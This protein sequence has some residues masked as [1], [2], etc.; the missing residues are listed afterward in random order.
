MFLPLL[1]LTLIISFHKISFSQEEQTTALVRIHVDTTYDDTED[2]L[3]LI[4]K[5]IE[6]LPTRRVKLESGGT[7]SKLILDEYGFGPSDL[8]KSYAL[9]EAAILSRNELSKPEDAMPGE[10]SIPHVPKRALRLFNKNKLLNFVS[11]IAYF[12]RS[13]LAMITDVAEPT[14]VE[15]VE[16]VAAPQVFEAGRP[17]AQ[18]TVDDLEIPAA[19]AQDILEDE[20][21]ATIATGFNLPMTV[22]LASA[23]GETSSP[24]DTPHPA[25]NEEERQLIRNMLATEA[26]RDVLVFIADTG[27]PDDATYIQ[28]RHNLRDVLGFIWKQ[29]F[30]RDLPSSPN[31]KPFATPSHKHCQI[32]ERSLGEF[33][34]LDP[35]NRIK[36]VYVPM[37]KEQD[38]APVLIELL[39]TSYLIDHL[40][41][42]PGKVPDDV[43]KRAR[44]AAEKVVAENFPSKWEGQE[45]K[46]DKAVLDALLRVGDKY[47]EKKQ[48]LF[49]LNESWTVPIEELFVAYPSLLDGAVIAA[50]GNSMENVNVSLRDFAQ[51]SVRNK[52]TLAVMNMNR[53]GSLQCLSSRIDERDIDDAF[54]VAFDGRV[55]G[56]DSECGT[57]F[58]APRVAWLLAMA[59]AIRRDQ[60]EPSRWSILLHQRLVNARDA[61]V[62]GF[63]KLWLSPTRF[64]RQPNQ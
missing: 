42:K 60:L 27:W 24:Q 9:L 22:D 10:Y 46:T 1:S 13:N 61:N 35:T 41:G 54:A 23:S 3:K 39:Q 62:T 25:L 31:P 11:K 55:S 49:F 26:Q 15:D 5:L 58:A 59:E 19:V 48:S 64:L 52:D 38:G 2:S 8:P 47:A 6:K 56:S 28:S 44:K 40:R 32:I 7:I 16:M 53:E 45:V 51:R 57:S 34:E 33:R 63:G 30:D 4:S 20:F 37:T 17:A 43:V 50:V 29:Y 14:S 21:M 18:S 36:I 12:S